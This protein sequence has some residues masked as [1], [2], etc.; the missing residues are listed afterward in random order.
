MK[1]LT[2][3]LLCMVLVLSV[4]GVNAAAAESECMEAGVTV[5]DDG[6]V[7]VAVNGKL[8]AANAHL[9]VDF[10]S[11]YLTYVDCDT[12]YAAHSVKAEDGKLTIGL[13]NPSNADEALELIDLRFEMTGR[14]DETALALTAVRY[15]GK[16]VDETVSLAVIGEGYR[17]DDVVARKWYFEAV[18]YMAS[19]GYI[20]GITDRCFGPEESMTRAAF[21]TLLGRMEGVEKRNVQTQFKDVPVNSYYSGYVAWAVEQGITTGMT[22][23]EF[24]PNEP[25]N[26]AQMATFLYR[27]A[28]SEGNDVSVVDPEGALSQFPDGNALPKYS[29]DA[30]VWAVE[31][32]IIN[33]MGGRLAP[34]G[35]AT[36]AQG[37]MV[38]YRFFFED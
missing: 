15:G 11:H 6:T 17:F 4:F 34:E 7:T 20:L 2:S 23:T 19:E 36:R 29:R 1:K 32:G 10:D 9:T 13:A 22:A 31:Q 16:T 27:Y 21:V 3:L 12:P 25:I 30:F 33:G 28:K 37:A 38:L 14:W 18:D 24:A 26:R 5:A 8:P 35:I